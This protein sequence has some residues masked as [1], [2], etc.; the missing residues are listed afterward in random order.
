MFSICISREE[1]GPTVA[2]I[3]WTRRADSQ[4]CQGEFQDDVDGFSG[5]GIYLEFFGEIVG[6]LLIYI[7]VAHNNFRLVQGSSKTPREISV[8]K[9]VS[10]DQFALFGTKVLAELPDSILKQNK[11]LP[12]FSPAVFLH[13]DFASMGSVVMVK[14]R[15]GQELVIRTFIAKSP[16]WCCRLK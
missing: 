7:C 12:R 1:S 13:P 4:S 8:G 5:D 10:K 3:C 2:R 15:V 9:S 14:V 6:R 11:N 16:S